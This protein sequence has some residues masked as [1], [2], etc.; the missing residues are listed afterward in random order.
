MY[1]GTCRCMYVL[2]SVCVGTC[3][4]MYVL[5][6]VCVGG[7]EG[8][9]ACVMGAD[10]TGFCLEHNGERALFGSASLL[11]LLVAVASHTPPTR[12]HSTNW[13]NGPL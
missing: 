5:V 10:K 6:S 11:Q 9:S 13:D 2:V 8:V 1:V 4:C 12:A 7:G 3:R